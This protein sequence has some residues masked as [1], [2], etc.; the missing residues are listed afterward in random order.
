MTVDKFLER[1]R[2]KHTEKQKLIGFVFGGTIFIGGI[3][4]AIIILSSFID[5]LLCLPK[6]TSNVII[7]F[8]LI[9][10]GLSLS[11]WAG[12]AQ[13]RIGKG[14]PVP[15][16]PTQKLVV[17]GPYK[18]CR[19]PIALGSVVYY[20]GICILIGSLSAFSLTLLFMLFSIAYLKLVEEKELEARFGEEYVEYKKRTPF[21]IPR[22]RW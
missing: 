13:L 14:T 12:Y 4:A 3:P 18:F 2:K 10:I 15:A 7:A 17:T 1:F 5:E 11:A 16:I 19:N 20:L 21:L 8:P 22:L 6:L 9:T